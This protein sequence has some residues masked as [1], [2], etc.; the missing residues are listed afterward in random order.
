LEFWINTRLSMNELEVSLCTPKARRA[1]TED[2]QYPR[3]CIR[4]L[5]LD[6]DEREKLKLAY[7]AYIRCRRLIVIDEEGW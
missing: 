7:D 1:C 5:R 3:M 6:F 4:V 2:P